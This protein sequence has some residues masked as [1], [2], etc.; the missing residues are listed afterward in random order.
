MGFFLEEA[1]RILWNTPS[2]RSLGQALVNVFL[3]HIC[4]RSE[5]LSHVEMLIHAF[6]ASPLILVVFIVEAVLRL[7]IIFGAHVR[8]RVF[9]V[10]IILC[11]G[12]SFVTRFDVHE[13]RLFAITDGNFIDFIARH[14]LLH[15]VL[16]RDLLLDGG[17][18]SGE[19]KSTLAPERV[20][21]VPELLVVSCR[22]VV[23]GSWR[24]TTSKINVSALKPCELRSR[25]KRPIWVG[26]SMRGGLLL[27]SEAWQIIVSSTCLVEIRTHSFHELFFACA[28][29]YS[30]LGRHRVGNHRSIF[31]YKRRKISYTIHIMKNYTYS[32][33]AMSCF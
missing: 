29:K 27:S 2:L 30:P 32:V 22:G 26:F 9:D 10:G 13:I 21:E 19:S 31:S 25:L 24:G 20:L 18:V 5:G 17:D 8:E 11:G 16:A 7:W 3:R 12:R 14:W 1:T 15:Q 23:C 6:V 4:S 28:V 33:V